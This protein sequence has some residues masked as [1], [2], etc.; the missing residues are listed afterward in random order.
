VLANVESVTFKKRVVAKLSIS[1]GPAAAALAERASSD[2]TLVL[3]DPREF[4][5]GVERVKSDKGQI[6]LL[7]EGGKNDN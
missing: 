7:D 5:D 6:P 2:I 4:L 1:R 3:A